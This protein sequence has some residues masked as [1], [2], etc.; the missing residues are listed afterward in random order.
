M[1]IRQT[2]IIE[3]FADFRNSMSAG[4]NEVYRG[5]GRLY[6]KFETNQKILFEKPIPAL[7]PK[8]KIIGEG[9]V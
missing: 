9:K 5:P 4:W 7:R 3:I 6:K 8:K 2:Q 1:Y